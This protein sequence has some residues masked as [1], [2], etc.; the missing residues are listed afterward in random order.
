[1]KKAKR[2][3]ALLGVL[4]IICA[5]AFIISRQEEKKEKIKNSD[6]VIL[7]IDGESVTAL[8]WEYEETSLAFHKEE[9]W[10]YDA[11]G[12]FPVDE[13]KIAALL[14]LFEE[15]GASFEIEEVE[16]LSQYGLDEPVCTIHLTTAEQEYT[17]ALGTYSTM[18]EERYV[19]I[20]DGKVYLVSHDPMEDYELVLRDLIRQD[21]IPSLTEVTAIRFGGM[22]NYKILHEEDGTASYCPDDI[23]FTDNAP[24]DTTLVETYL[25]TVAGV[26]LSE[27]VT[28]NVT[29]EELEE[30]GLANPELT[31]TVDYISEK[32]G[33]A[34]SAETFVLQL[35]RNKEEL[36]AALATGDEDELYGV[37][38]YARVGASP[39]VY[40]ITSLAYQNLTKNSYQDL[41]HREILTAD[42]AEIYQI[43]IT[44]ENEHYTLSSAGEDG[45]ST[46]SYMG[47]ELDISGLQSAVEAVKA[48]DAESFTEEA[49]SGKEEICFTVYLHNE[50][51][52]EVKVELYRCNGQSCLAAVDGKTVAY[53]PRSTVVELVEAVNSI[54]LN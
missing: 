13:E 31:V 42:F 16:E 7:N 40:E 45:E 17:I 29:E 21:E 53:V 44:L 5:A 2:I 48:A 22:Q 30:Y 24:L 9:E 54:V 20:G 12:A 15:F 25:N 41:R 6:A 51:Y 3:Y 34:S 33:E 39:I 14:G 27:Y 26:D 49:P 50:N 8:S 46:W 18:D 4:L 10:L 11:D 52:P 32:E 35:G 47:E 28:Y 43:D 36:E 23:Y 38:A 19:S 37:T 1:M